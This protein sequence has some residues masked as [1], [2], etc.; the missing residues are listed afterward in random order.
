MTTEELNAIIAKAEGGDITAMNRLTQIYCE[1]PDF[2]DHEQ[3]AKW[4]LELIKRDCDSN[5]GVY[6]NTGYNKELYAKIK[7]V[8]L[9]STTEEEMMSAMSGDNGGSLLGGAISF[10]TSSAKSYINQA[11]KA[12][13]RNISHK[14]EQSRIAAEEEEKCRRK[15]EEARKKAEA[16]AELARRKAEEEKF[17]NWA[18]RRGIVDYPKYIRAKGGG[19]MG[20]LT[21][22]GYKN[23]REIYMRNRSYRGVLLLDKQYYLYCER[24][25]LTLQTTNKEET[26]SQRKK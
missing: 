6:E 15:E 16:E 9:N 2:I 7:T 25:L 11:E 8:I 4:F 24:L 20:G 10:T 14:E 23:V 17:E 3:A 5:S 1:V 21:Y 18:K 19:R 12:I 13:L 22:S 26:K